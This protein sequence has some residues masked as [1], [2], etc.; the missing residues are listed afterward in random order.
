[1]TTFATSLKKE[2]ARVARRELKSE[3]EAMRRTSTGYRSE[4]AALKKQLRETSARIRQ[5]EKGQKQVV[6]ALPAPEEPE[7]T[8]KPRAF[9][10]ESFAAY[11]QK[12]GLT[13]ADM[14]KL[15]GVSSL[16]IWKWESGQVVPRERLNAAIRDAYKLGKREV[17]ER[18]AAA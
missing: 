14:A 13:Q 9:N 17:K 16:S 18:L 4:I 10:A 3:L 12:M 15:L 8:R 1:M 2:I 7:H 11:R 6:K 5:L